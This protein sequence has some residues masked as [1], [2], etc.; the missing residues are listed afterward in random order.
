MH[1]RR[2]REATMYIYVYVVRHLLRAR[3][4]T[5]RAQPEVSRRGGTP[6]DAIIIRRSTVRISIPY[7]FG[8]HSRSLL[9]S[10]LEFI[11]SGGKKIKNKHIFKRFSYSSAYFN[12][13]ILK[14]ALGIIFLFADIK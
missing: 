10:C 13:W 4:S 12:M 3:T 7:T 14:Q 6:R 11:I 1:V 9:P 8:I 5:S 2:E